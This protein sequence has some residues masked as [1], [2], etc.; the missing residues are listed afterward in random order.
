MEFI[1]KNKISKD[2]LKSYNE[3]MYLG[4]LKSLEKD[5]YISPFDGLKDLLYLRELLIKRP[6]LKSDYIHLLDQEPFNAN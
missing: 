1:S 6:D 5:K 2:L 3:E 4:L